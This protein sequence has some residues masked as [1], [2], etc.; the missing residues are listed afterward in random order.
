M[1][2]V[3][4]RADGIEAPQLMRVYGALLW[5]LSR[6][7][8]TPEVCRFVLFPTVADLPLLL[9]RATAVQANAATS[10][11]PVSA[12]PLWHMLRDP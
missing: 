4:N 11:V 7:L 6:V 8:R 9:L 12:A 2:V 10:A 1:R 3:L 5:S